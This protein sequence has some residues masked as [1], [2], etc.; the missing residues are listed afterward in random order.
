MGWN[1]NITYYKDL[2]GGKSN[3]NSEIKEIMY[4]W[5]ESEKVFLKEEV[6]YL[7]LEGSGD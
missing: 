2:R 6:H 3:G 5:E 4:N 1:I 7:H